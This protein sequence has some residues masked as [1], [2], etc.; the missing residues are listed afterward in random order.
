MSQSVQR[1]VE[2]RKTVS[3]PANPEVVIGFTGRDTRLGLDVLLLKKNAIARGNTL[4]GEA[5]II[6]DEQHEQLG[7]ETDFL[8]VLNGDDVLVMD[9]VLARETSGLHT[10]DFE[11]GRNSLN[12]LHLDG[13]FITEDRDNVE[14]TL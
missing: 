10:F 1:I 12:V 4:G 2:V 3:H 6:P 9:G 7:E 13:P 8:L 5:V 11:S 14:V